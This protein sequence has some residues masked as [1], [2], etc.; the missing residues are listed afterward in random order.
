[1]GHI[2][3]AKLLA[4]ILLVIGTLGVAGRVPAEDT[5]GLMKKAKKAKRLV[6]QGLFPRREIMGVLK[7]GQTR[8]YAPGDDGALEKGF[9][10][11][12]PRF[13]DHG[14]G[15]VTDK[16]TGLMWTKNAQQI[17]GKH[18]WHDAIE[19]CNGLDFGGYQNWRLP[20][21]REMLSLVDYGSHSP[22]LPQNH[23]FDNVKPSEFFWSSTTASKH[24][25]QAWIVGLLNGSVHRKGKAG[26]TFSA[27]PVRRGRR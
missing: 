17:I 18:K 26:Q 20:N 24:E 14:N 8:T 23:P 1:M 15:T 7:T 11:P 9:D 10:W 21:V 3:F 19:L 12:D 27:W 25:A 16:V 13:V 6:K 4:A 5:S 22:A 2:R